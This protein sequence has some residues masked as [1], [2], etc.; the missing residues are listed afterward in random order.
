VIEFGFGNI[1]TIPP[2]KFSV[3]INSA[4]GNY[5]TNWDLNQ[6]Y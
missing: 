4:Y 3:Q 6:Y 2:F 1:Y 5:F